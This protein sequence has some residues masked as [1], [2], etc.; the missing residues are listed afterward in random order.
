MTTTAE[1]ATLLSATAAFMVAALGLV[2]YWQDRS[3]KR[4]MRHQEAT[5]ANTM[6]AILRG[7]AAQTMRQ[8][9]GIPPEQIYSLDVRLRSGESLRVPLL[10][11]TWVQYL[12]SLS[13]MLIR[14]GKEETEFLM[15]VTDP[16]F[17]PWHSH[18]GTETVTVIRGS[19]VDLT[20]ARKYLPG[21]TWEIS[22]EQWHRA[23]FDAGTLCRVLIRPPLE[24]A[25]LHP[26]DLSHMEQA[27]AYEDQSFR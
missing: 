9:A 27:F 19:M 22:A 14:S 11:K 18:T 12:P 25:A 13:L 8:I 6:R 2:K 5:M 3:E 16:A 21:E 17:L 1:I 7:L 23:Q 15:D 4:I 20:T 24:T 10:E 26:I